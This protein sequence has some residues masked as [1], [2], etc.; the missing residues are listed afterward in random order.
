[1]AEEVN[2]VFGAV[3]DDLRGKMTEV[4]G[5][6]DSLASKFKTLAAVVAGGAAFK[7]FIDEANQTNI[8][9][10]KMS[11]TLGIT[12][13]EAAILGVA[14]DDV[15]S[16]MGA[17]A[18]PETYTQAFLKFNRALRS[19]RDEMRAMGVDVDALANGSKTSNQVF[20]ES[21]QIVGRYKP[22]V[23]QTQAAMRLFGRSIEDVQVLMRVNSKAIEEARQS[24]QAL[25][26]TVSQ[27][28]IKAAEAY[29][30]AIDNVG[31]VLNG[32]KKTIG[33]AFIPVFT[34][35]SNKLASFG[36]AI[37]AVLKPLAAAFAEVWAQIGSVTTRA[38]ESIVGGAAKLAGAVARVFGGADVS[39]ADAFR[40]ILSAIGAAFEMAAGTAARMFDVIDGVFSALAEEVGRVA[41][42]LRAAFQG[43]F[44]DT[45]ALDIL[46]TALGV[47]EA[48]FRLFGEIAVQAISAVGAVLSAL[49]ELAAPAWAMLADGARTV[50]S[51][52]GLTFAEEIPG[53]MSVFT[54]TLA[55]VHVLFIGFRVGVELI[56][57]AVKTMFTSLGE[58]MNRFANVARAAFALDW[59]GVK[60]AWAKG[61][62]D[63]KKILEAGMAD[64]V[65]IASKGAEDIQAAMNRPSGFKKVEPPKVDAAAEKKT[66]PAGVQGGGGTLTFKDPKQDEAAFAGMLSIQK[67]A[68]DAAQALTME[69]LKQGQALYD[70]AYSRNLLSTKDYFEA[71]K[72]IE[73]RGIDETIDARV[74][75]IEAAR[76][77]AAQ[78]GVTAAQRLQFQAAEAKAIGEI[79][80]LEAQRAGAV[81]RN[82]SEYEAAERKRADALASTAAGS[83]RQLA[84]IEI[85]GALSLV[86]QKQA[87]GE[88]D[89]QEAL[90]RETELQFEL[91]EVAKRSLDDRAELARGDLEKMAQ[92]DADRAALE[93]STQQK[94]TDIARRAALDRQRFSI[95]GA[96]AFENSFR[97]SIRSLLNGTE[98]LSGAFK[99]FT[100]GVAEQF[101][102]LIAQ[103]FAEKIFGA[104]ADL[105]EKMTKPFSDAIGR[106]VDDFAAFF[107][108]KQAIQ[109]AGDATEATI[110]AG[111]TA[112]RAAMQAAETTTV[113]TGQAAKTAAVS[114]GAGARAGAEAAASATVVGLQ[115]AEAAGEV[116]SQAAQTGAVVAGVAT[117]TAAEEGAASQS[118]VIMAATAVKR[119]AIAAWEAAASVYAA[120]AA[121]PFVG[122][123]LAPAMAIAAGVAVL[124]FAKNIASAEGGWWQ[125]PGNTMTQIHKDEMVMPAPLAQGVRDKVLGKGDGGGGSTYNINAV[126]AKSFKDLLMSNPASV[127]EAVKAHVRNGGSAA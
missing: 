107:T 102:G 43:A 118:L 103:K 59:A 62:D 111:A 3:I 119:I 122:P 79:R 53:K 28:S 29:R 52:L 20:E 84:E 48:A 47:A 18:G 46:G 26:L 15:A 2:V 34:E 49:I 85:G 106:M 31:D 39:G 37:I 74:R 19:N 81:A 38:I 100:R 61:V 105:T 11:R 64:A 25:N 7:A 27:E 92:I 90:R 121:I 94:I 91:Y 82:A 22:G 14:I 80:V 21:L 124:G 110:E 95:D 88:I 101:D 72:A 50:G 117:R 10:E 115:A 98:T 127:A 78:A 87:L 116:G 9:A 45:S 66:T 83:R 4:A 42:Q 54:A 6:F 12:A 41:D 1:M 17:S 71:K 23:D 63:Q 60:A 77:Q 93:A 30:V 55:T 109:Q 40:T 75:D 97:D 56:V 96:K 86:Q 68:Q 51:V 126:D 36:P 125:V 104:G 65:R 5:I 58:V 99:N 69:Y 32:I 57:S 108:G 35:A 44:G 70:D 8:A 24:A 113:A 13:D 89:A 123:F 67:A 33:E 114:A 76:A 120:I 16:K 112:R 73:L